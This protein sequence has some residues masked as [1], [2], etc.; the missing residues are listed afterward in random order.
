MNKIL[1]IILVILTCINIAAFILYFIRPY[2][3]D[4]YPAPNSAA[5]TYYNSYPTCCN[6]DAC[7]KSK[8]GPNKLDPALCEELGKKNYCSADSKDECDKY[9]GC[10]YQGQMTACGKNIIS[11]DYL[12]TNFVVAFMSKEQAVIKT[13]DGRIAYWNKNHG[14]Q[15][16]QITLTN[17]KDK[18]KMIVFTA[19]I[20]D[21]CDDGDCD[22][23]CSTN[24]GSHDALID[25]EY[26]SLRRLSDDNPDFTS[27]PLIDFFVKRC[28]KICDTC[29]KKEADHEGE[30]SKA[31][32]CGQGTSSD[33][34]PALLPYEVSWVLVRPSPGNNIP[35]PDRCCWHK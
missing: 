2:T 32:P 16:I 17:K 22:G 18:N 19:I 24:M 26:A 20:L 7:K 31:V 13:R 21:T 6:A 25:I 12:K 27:T 28:S 8:A 14:K 11:E 4:S 23:C 1:I 33:Y 30:C 10:D 3:P 34:Q 29:E 9:S 35:L 5:M 15:S